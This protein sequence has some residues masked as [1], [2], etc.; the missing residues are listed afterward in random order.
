MGAKAAGA[1]SIVGIDLNATKFPMAMDFGA[2]ECLN[3][4]VITTT[5]TTTA[6]RR[7]QQQ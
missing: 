2:T 5:T 1:S 7:E 3:P 6:D 4:K